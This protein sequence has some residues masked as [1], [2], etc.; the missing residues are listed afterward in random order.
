[1][2]VGGSAFLSVDS[3][4]GSGAVSTVPRGL[5][6]SPWWLLKCLVCRQPLTFFS[7]SET[8]HDR[9]SSE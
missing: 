2:E 4:L 3:C 8:V 6:F 1:M 9:R 7:P 5:G